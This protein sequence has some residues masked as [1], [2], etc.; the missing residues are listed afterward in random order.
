MSSNPRAPR[1]SALAKRFVKDWRRLE[2]SGRY[3]MHELSERIATELITSRDFRAW[4][5]VFSG[6]GRSP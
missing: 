2:R 5:M 4:L 1:K 6:G 3:A